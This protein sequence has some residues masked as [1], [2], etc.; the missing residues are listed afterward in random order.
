MKNL[1]IG[2]FIL[3]LTNLSYSQN[4]VSE[5]E[6]IG[7]IEIKNSTLP[8]SKTISLLNIPYLDKVQNKIKP[9]KIRQLEIAAFK[10]N[11]KKG[12]AFN[13]LRPE[14][15]EFKWS[16]NYIIA[17]Y[18]QDGKILTTFEEFKDF[19]LPEN[20]SKPI[21]LDYPNWSIINNI[22]R[23]YYS[24]KNGAKMEYI[25]T[26]K[27]DNLRKKIKIDTDGNYTKYPSSLVVKN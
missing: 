10:Y 1:L 16:E 22:Y 18:D 2:L 19:E 26:I 21:L 15:V 14:V 11:V 4:L 6:V 7:D 8:V 23:V 24:N 5:L 3:G 13:Y 9:S 25:V 17:K 12:Y 27:K 20:I